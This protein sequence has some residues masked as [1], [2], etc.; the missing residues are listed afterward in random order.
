[1]CPRDIYLNTYFSES[2]CHLLTKSLEL[3][4]KK[5][6]CASVAT[7]FA[8]YD[9]PVPGGPYNRMPFHG[10]R[11]PVKRVGNFSGKI[12]ASFNDAFA[13]SKPAI[14]SHL[15]LGVSVNIAWRRPA[16]SFLVSE[17]SVL[18]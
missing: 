6:L 5:V 9:L 13:P 3:I 11:I 14:S 8:R 15:T 18:S 2:P 1:M 7:A 4:L 10:L 16:R 17:S 12:T